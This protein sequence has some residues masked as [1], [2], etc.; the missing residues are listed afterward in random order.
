[1]V[2]DALAARMTNGKARYDDGGKMA[3]AAQ[4]NPALL[5]WMMQDEYLKRTPPKTTGREMYGDA[6]V[7]QLLKKANE[8]DVPLG[9]VLATATRFTAEC[10]SAGVRDY[11]PVKPDRMI[12]GG[13]AA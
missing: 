11:C 1:M 2:I 8:L 9:D 4:V 13:A 6:Y 7:E 3:A 12:V 10:I 5:A